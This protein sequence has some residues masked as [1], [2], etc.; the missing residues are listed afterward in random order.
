[1]ISN[2]KSLTKKAKLFLFEIMFLLDFVSSFCNYGTVA[3][4][5]EETN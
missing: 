1:M 3:I 5:R 4:Y 2:K